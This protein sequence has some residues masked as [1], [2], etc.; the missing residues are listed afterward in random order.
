MSLE[1]TRV[2]F[3]NTVALEIVEHCQHELDVKHLVDLAP[4]GAAT[5]SD[6]GRIQSEV[7]KPRL[8]RPST[9]QPE[10]LVQ[11][12]AAWSLEAAQK[13]AVKEN[14]V[15]HE[16]PRGEALDDAVR[17]RADRLRPA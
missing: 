9:D 3:S 6:C 12:R 10:T 17:D 15:R 5:R 16:V 13:R 4:D 7:V 11:P 8:D 2:G 14:Q 1:Q